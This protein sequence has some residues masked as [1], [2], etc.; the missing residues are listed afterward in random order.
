MQTLTIKVKDLK[1]GDYVVPAKATVEAVQL[2]AGLAIV[3]FTDRT[4][5]PPI[6]AQL[7]VEINRK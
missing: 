7:S 2:F 3:D 6:P 1:A 4:A 5:T